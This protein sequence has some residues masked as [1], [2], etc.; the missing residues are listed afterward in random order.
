MAIIGE[1]ITDKAFYTYA[2]PSLR[3]RYYLALVFSTLLFPIIAAALLAGTVVLVVPFFAFLLWLGMRVLFA[4]LIGNAILVSEINYPRINTIS[5]EMKNAIG[6][7]KKVYIFVYESRSFNAYMK[8]IFFR[9]AIFLNSELL[10][11][12]VS[13]DELRWIVG[14]F[15]GYLRARRQAGVLGWMIRAAQH[16]LIFNIFLL[17]YERAMVYTGDRLA[18]VAINGDIA[19]AISTMQK[20]LVGRE[21]GYSI[22]PEGIIDQQRQIKGSFFAFLARFLQAFPHMTARYVDLIVFSMI[23]FPTQF[24]RFAA[25][26]PG[27][28]TDL[29]LLASPGQTVPPPGTRRPPPTAHRRP[30]GWVCVGTTAATLLLLGFISWSAVTRGFNRATEVEPVFSPSEATIPPQQATPA[31]QPSLPPHVHRNAAGELA[32]DPGCAWVSNAPDDF[33]VRCR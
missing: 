12:G 13:D 33:R 31:A 6:F 2:H 19:S 16:L 21:L 25:A 11:N 3:G 17:P 8:H 1:K 14:R 26:N 15:V 18:C 5:E 23:F 4:Y 27:L 30:R 9:R 20:L 28:P 7:N 32:P 29:P 24:A 22:N 10:E